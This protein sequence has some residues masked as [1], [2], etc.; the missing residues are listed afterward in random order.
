MESLLTLSQSSVTL[1]Q[2]MLF[3]YSAKALDEKFVSYGQT[4]D[5]LKRISGK[6]SSGTLDSIQDT[7]TGVLKTRA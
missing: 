5:R 2:K 7:F 3:A 1:S 6:M 4:S